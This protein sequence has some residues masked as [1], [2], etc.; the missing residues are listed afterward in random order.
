MSI[1]FFRFRVWITLNVSEEDEVEK[2]NQE[3]LFF[4]EGIFEVVENSE[5]ELDKFRIVIKTKFSV[6]QGTRIHF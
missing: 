1:G 5:N 4:L 3:W 2:N 6:L